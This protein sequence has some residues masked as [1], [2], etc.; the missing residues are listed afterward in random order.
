M[1]GILNSKTRVLDS[2][3]TQEGKRQIGMGNLNVV[4]ATVSDKHTYYESSETS[5]SS[6]ATS[7]IYFEAPVENVSDFITF[8]TDDSGKLLGYPTT[9]D[10]YLRSDGVI[11]NQ[12][13][14]SGGMGYTTEESF[15]GFASL[16]GGIITS[17]IDHFRDLYTIG[18][19]EAGELDT[20]TFKIS[21]TSKTFTVN[22]MFPFVSGPSDAIN[23]VDAVEI[24]FF[25]DRLSNIDN[26][27]FLPPIIVDA[28]LGSTK[29]WS[30]KDLLGDYYEITRPEPLTWL[31]IWAHLTQQSIL[32]TISE[33]RDLGREER[34]LDGGPFSADDSVDDS[35]TESN[36]SSY[37]PFSGNSQSDYGSSINLTSDEE[38]REKAIVTF[39]GRSTTNNIV[40]QLF[41]INSGTST[42]T[43][44]DV[45]DYGPVQASANSA[46]GSSKHV[47]FAGK[48]FINRAGLP[49]FVNLFTIVM[50]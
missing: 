9:P 46:G 28:K 27:K 30:K 39:P 49:V 34:S 17:S 21:P 5:G 43:K 10:T 15:Q 18:T 8:E 40:M 3:I 42:M 38:A 31:D 41:E 14:T 37:D 1:A 35:A 22:N 20:L 47:F 6:D 32:A 16:A 36:G 4:Y 7:R 12:I 23:D 33:L 44:L 13:F 24:L 26:F 29:Q 50:D 25:D 2:I 48:M 45:I 11:E 19:R